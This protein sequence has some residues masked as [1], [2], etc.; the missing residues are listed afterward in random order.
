MQAMY[1]WYKINS[2]Y[3]S[4]LISVFLCLETC[5]KNSLEDQTSLDIHDA[6]KYSFFIKISEISFIS[7]W[8]KFEND[9]SVYFKELNDAFLYIWLSV[10]LNLSDKK[11]YATLCTLS[12]YLLPFW[13]P[14]IDKLS[15]ANKYE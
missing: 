11:I 13:K 6:I 2:V 3:N 15:L 5:N 8:E 12:E 9:I 10:T 1:V 4:R 14:T 7:L